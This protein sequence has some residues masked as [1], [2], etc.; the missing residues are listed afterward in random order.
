MRYLRLFEGFENKRITCG[1]YLFDSNNK[2]LIQ[3][4]TGFR[5]TIWGIPKGRIDEGET[6]FFE[7]AKRELFEETGIVLDNYTII[8][9]EYLGESRYKD[10][11]KYLVS[12]FVKIEEDLS[13]LNLYCDSMVIRNGVPAFPE[14]D[15][16]KW[17]T[18]EEAKE[19]FTSD[20]KTNFQT[21]NLDKCK[22]Y[23][24]K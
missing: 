23:L 20:I 8:K 21:D 19:I 5:P 17:V 15:E 3:H 11:N 6:D 9:K 2:F 1:I 12:F 18:I 16:W 24:Y 4:P 14:V 22:E 10:S 7:V 13:D